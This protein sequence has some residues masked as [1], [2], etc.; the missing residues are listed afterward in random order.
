MVTGPHCTG[1]GR[2]EPDCEGCQQAFDA[3]RFCPACGRRLTVQVAPTRVVA[4]CRD[5]GAVEAP[6]HG[7]SP[8]Q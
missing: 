5:H 7:S 3:P 1:C 6:T 2:T 4:R 8:R